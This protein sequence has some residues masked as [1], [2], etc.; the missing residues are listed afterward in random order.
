MFD[1]YKIILKYLVIEIL[2]EFFSKIILFNSYIIY[3]CN[4][5]II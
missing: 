5:I 2:V 4:L 1:F 3:N